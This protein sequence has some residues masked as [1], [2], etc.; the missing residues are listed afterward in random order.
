MPNEVDDDRLTQLL[1]LLRH[2]EGGAFCNNAVM[3]HEVRSMAAE[4]LRY[5]DRPL[6][7]PGCDGDHS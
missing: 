2:R 6:H 1:D 4:L 7:C 3:V 5:R